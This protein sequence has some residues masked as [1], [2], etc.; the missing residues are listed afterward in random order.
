MNTIDIIGI[1]ALAF[2]S[3]FAIG[4]VTVLTMYIRDMENTK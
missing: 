3:G 2:T 4:G 1:I